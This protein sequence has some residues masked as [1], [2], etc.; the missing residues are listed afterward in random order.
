MLDGID[1]LRATP[2]ELLAHLVDLE[3]GPLVMSVLLIV[4]RAA[5][6][7]DEAVTFVQVHERVAAWWASVQV[8]ALVAAA[9]SHEVVLELTIRDAR[10]GDPLAEQERTIRIRDAAREEIAAA[11]RWSPS[12]AHH[13]I[14]GARLLAGPLARTARALALGEIS[15]GHV[16][17]I[18]EAAG[19]LP[20]RG[21]FIAGES[22]DGADF[23]A[24][25][26]A[27]QDR[28]LPV[29][30]RGTLAV[31]RSAARRAVL[32]IDAAGVQRRRREARSTRG[33]CVVDDLD[34]ISTL[35]ARM[36][37]ERAHAVMAAIDA[38]AQATHARAHAVG[39]SPSGGPAVAGADPVGPWSAAA[40]PVGSWSAAADPVGP[41][42]AAADPFGP[43]SWGEH[44]AEAL[45]DL[46]LGH[47][48]VTAHLDLVI[49]LPTLQ[50]LA[51]EAAMP[52]VGVVAAA[53][54]APSAETPS[55]PAGAAS[56]RGAGA[57]DAGM[58]AD[59]LA[60]PAIAVTMRRLV[61]DPV[62]G[63]LLDVGRRSY[64]V[65]D[66]LRRFVSTRDQY[67]RF[68]GCRRRAER[69]QV[70][71][72]VPWEDGGGTGPANLGALCLR[73]HQLKTH[74]GWAIHGSGPD[75]SCTWRS[76]TGRV[77]EH[78]PEPVL[79]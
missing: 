54:A 17:V 21:A 78:P 13:R 28:V 10:P 40:D 26:E 27:L 30:R 18:V 1:P 46:V 34:G 74:G 24:A 77:Y 62:T 4:D 23:A 38:R 33:V 2:R 5:L 6:S 53:P 47:A 35:I 12:A 57:I 59:L 56:L 71:H 73:H 64:A 36:A 11:A 48:Q 68:P 58:V 72:A 66:A 8:D 14:T 60:D 55:G 20:G 25:C 41:W 76:P 16:A 61:V 63:H 29:A 79:A 37:T 22:C 3:P 44:R 31:T 7:P 75:G 32:A 70:D 9:S 67:C 15:T 69:C 51:A 39:P 42:S 49:D 43:R 19:S 65:P 45:A 50:H 52:A